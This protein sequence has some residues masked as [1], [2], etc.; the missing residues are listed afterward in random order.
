MDALSRCLL[1]RR[2]T[3]IMGHL[4]TTRLHTDHWLRMQFNYFSSP[5]IELLNLVMQA[6]CLSS[7][8]PHLHHIRRCSVFHPGSFPNLLALIIRQKPMFGHDLQDPPTSPREALVEDPQA[9]EHSL[10]APIDS[11]VTS[12]NRCNRYF[13]IVRISH[14]F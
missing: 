6:F 12:H 4:C 2:A 14:F 5:K 9:S 10:P 11:Q 13:Q 1:V 7:K 3:R 8:S